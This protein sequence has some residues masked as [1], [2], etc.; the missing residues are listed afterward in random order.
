MTRKDGGDVRSS[1]QG[2]NFNPLF[3]SPAQ[4]AAFV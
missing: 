1:E 4:G 2:V 3:S